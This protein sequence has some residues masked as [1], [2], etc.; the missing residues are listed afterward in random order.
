M[1]HL[2]LAALVFSMHHS[3][4]A[5]ENG[6]DYTPFG[7]SENVSTI[8]LDETHYAAPAVHL[9]VLHRF[10][11]E[12]DI[13][14]YRA[15]HANIPFI[16]TG[17]LAALTF[18]SGSIERAFVLSDVLFPPLLL[19]LFYMLS[20]G[21]VESRFYRM[22]IAWSTL[23]IPFAPQDFTW[24][25]YDSRLNPPLVTR[26]PQPEISLVFLL[27][28]I[29][30]LARSLTLPSRWQRAF[31]AGVSAGLLIYCYYFYFVAC[32]AAVGLLFLLGLVWR[33]RTLARSAAIAVAGAVLAALPYLAVL[34][35]AHR[36]GGQALILERMATYTR[37]LYPEPLI[38][39]V[40]LLAAIVA[41]G[42][43]ASMKS[44]AHMR[45]LVT[46]VLIAAGLLISNIHVITGINVQNAHF[47]SRLSHPFF[48]FLAGVTV[49]HFLERGVLSRVWVRNVLAIAFALLV[50]SVAAHQ[51]L[52]A[53]HVAPYQ[54]K[55]GTQMQLV[56]WLRSNLLPE[57][58][59]G[60]VSPSLITLI[61]ALTADYS[62]VPT[63]NR[64][65]TATPEIFERFYELASALGLSQADV[66]RIA[67]KP[68]NLHPSELFLAFG[69]P[70]NRIDEFVQGY[71]A[72]LAT[73]QPELKYRLD[74]LVVPASGGIPS[75][76]ITLYP[77]AVVIYRNVDFQVLR[78]R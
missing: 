36:E 8:T 51:A 68:G 55:T 52:V 64:S 41:Y 37:H 69:L 40:V 60:T 53:S 62:Y 42:R 30:L 48:F 34:L 21:L 67:A 29:L 24:L 58:V 31:V 71:G 66:A 61:P 45:Y 28:A 23:A 10:V 12:T 56:Y 20:E 17:I 54:R 43:R 47:L 11:A 44:P 25:A 74:Y 4:A 59:V 14:E 22:L 76:V 49:F 75:S 73:R 63:G 5:W 70:P 77:R 32:F 33:N 3:V 15:L 78:L 19:L 1:F 38:E 18:A 9:A 50:G 27:A 57:S 46:A 26:T 35:V 39:G 13:Y 2:A 7:V 72:F 16:P 6:G 65:M